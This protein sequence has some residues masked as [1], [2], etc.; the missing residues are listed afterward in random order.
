MDRNANTAR[1]LAKSREGR[2]IDN[3]ILSSRARARKDVDSWRKAVQRAENIQ[4]PRRDLLLD[5]YA[6]VV[7]DPHISGCI[8]H[9]RLNKLLAQEFRI[10]G[11]DGKEDTE[12]TDA[13][14]SDWFFQFIELVMESLWYG[15]SLIEFPHIDPKDMPL[16]LLVPRYHV[17]PE[18]GVFLKNPSD[19]N[20]I[21]YR[22]TPLMDYLVEVGDPRDLGLLCKAAP[23]F[24]YKKNA[25]MSWSEFTELFGMPIRI[26]K[27]NTR[28]IEDLNRMEDMLR[29]LGSAAYG[30]FQEGEEIE[31][32]ESQRGDAYNVYDKLIARCNSELSKLFV[33]Q[34]M[35]TEVGQNGSRAQAEVHERLGDDVTSSDRRFVEAV[36][37]R[38]LFPVLL[39]HGWKLDG[40][41]FRFN[42]TK[43]VD[44]LWTRVRDVLPHATMDVEWMRETFGIHIIEQKAT[45]NDVEAGKT[46][47]HRQTLL[48]QETN[49]IYD[50]NIDM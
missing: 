12:L 30:V 38:G 34:T 2:V 49:R 50:G 47:N 41:E 33:G 5:L 6:D 42:E 37:K 44:Q 3:I 10:I 29:D 17:V 20:G 14:N 22:E 21:P 43:G 32:V 27:T 15:H 7:I 9:S 24:L 23:A 1:Y 26:G 16:P 45:K 25:T 36:V 4:A 18:F 39:K 48:M 13:F 35:T 19:S 28:S 8:E 46:L 40:K 11:K 31:F